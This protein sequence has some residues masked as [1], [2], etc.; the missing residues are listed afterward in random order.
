[1]AVSSVHVRSVC[2]A[3]ARPFV[4]VVDNRE[5]QRLLR[6]FNSA[7]ATSVQKLVLSVCHLRASTRL[8]AAGTASLSAHA[9]SWPTFHTAVWAHCAW[10]QGHLPAL[11]MNHF[12]RN[13]RQVSRKPFRSLRSSISV[14]PQS[15]GVHPAFREPLSRPNIFTMSFFVSRVLPIGFAIGF[16]IWNGPSR[17]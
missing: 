1:M 12:A 11:S 6:T 17:L 15:S 7:A 3:N 13:W 9:E 16:G 14:R 5:Y 10:L 8:M 4:R 2:S